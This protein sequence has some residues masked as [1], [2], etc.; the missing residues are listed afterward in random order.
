MSI[1]R[2][3]FT[4]T[5]LYF[6]FS[7]CKKSDLPNTDGQRLQRSI[8]KEGDSIL[9]SFFNYDDQDRLTAMTDSNNNGYVWKTFIDYNNQGNLVKFK[10]L[11]SSYPNSPINEVSYSLLYN[12][13]DQ[14]V[15]KR[16]TTSTIGP[17]KKIN[18]YSY[19][20]QGRLIGD[21]TYSYWNNEVFSYM[22]FIY[23]GNNDVI[24]WEEYSK[25]SGTMKS[26]GITTASY[27]R[28]DNPISNLGLGIYFIGSGSSLLSK[29][30]RIQT[31]YYDGTTE[32]YTY[33]YYN[34]GLLKKVVV[35]DNVNGS[36]FDVT[37]EFFYD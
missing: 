22:A 3:A 28:V 15:E 11:S 25:W 17:D 8:T 37:T 21:T 27:N 1:T 13:N 24:Q 16:V 34:N 9:Y 5:I 26:E 2:L 33:D 18:T 30:N 31:N 19:D 6:L 35:H 23:D 14:V 20:I 29:H 12:N 36:R 32:S 7:A 4:I 10:V